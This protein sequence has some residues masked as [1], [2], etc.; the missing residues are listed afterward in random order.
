M[1]LQ[2]IPAQHTRQQLHLLQQCYVSHAV[3][4]LV[5]TRT[6][7]SVDLTPPPQVTDTRTYK[8]PVKPPCA[9]PRR[10]I[11]QHHI[12]ISSVTG[13]PTAADCASQEARQHPASH[14]LQPNFITTNQCRRTPVSE[15]YKLWMAS[16]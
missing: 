6:G 9:S 8:R 12:S 3:L 1:L 13:A 4:K 10:N 14:Q 7:S 11:L 16:G 15:C 5:V 2:L